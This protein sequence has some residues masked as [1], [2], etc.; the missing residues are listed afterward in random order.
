MSR[1]L[2]WALGAV[3]I[4]ALTIGLWLRARDARVRREA[5]AAAAIQAVEAKRAQAD[6]TN[7]VLR[8]SLRSVRARTDTVRIVVTNTVQA[9]VRERAAVDTE[10]P[11][12]ANVPP[13][14]VVV[15]LSFVASADSLAK[16]VSVLNATIETERMAYERRIAALIRTDSLSR[17]INGQLHAQIRAARPGITD[18]LQWAGV[19][20][21]V[22]FGAVAIFGN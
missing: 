17:A 4:A 2:P 21:A 16:L 11:R 1:K 15:P 14:S 10:A 3:L 9:Y 20:A 19:G 22:A 6:S 5:T 12:P 8:D 18:R 7:A 13:G